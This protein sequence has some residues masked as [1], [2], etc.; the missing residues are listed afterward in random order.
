MNTL[1]ENLHYNVVYYSR[2]KKK[3]EKYTSKYV[4]KKLF[5][6]SAALM[7]QNKID[8]CK[9]LS[10]GPSKLQWKWLMDATLIWPVYFID[11]K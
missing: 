1:S 9:D 5:W 6:T 11:S 10:T 3:S 8:S 7:I 4:K 2:N